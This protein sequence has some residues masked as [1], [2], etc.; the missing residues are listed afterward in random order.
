MYHLIKP[1]ILFQPS[2]GGP[3]RRV[4]GMRFAGMDVAAAWCVLVEAGG[5]MVD[6]HTGC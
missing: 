4:L 1:R 2:R 6:G 3:A 5:L